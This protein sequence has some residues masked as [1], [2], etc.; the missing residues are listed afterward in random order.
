MPRRRRRKPYAGD[1][2]IPSLAAP[3]G[4]EARDRS[5]EIL[6]QRLVHPD[7]DPLEKRFGLHDKPV[8]FAEFCL[9]LLQIDDLH[10]LIEGDLEYLLEDHIGLWRE[11]DIFDEAAIDAA[12]PIRLASGAVVRDRHFASG[13]EVS[14]VCERLQQIRPTGAE[15]RYRLV[16]SGCTLADSE[17]LPEA[18]TETI[19]AV[20]TDC[21]KTSVM[22]RNVPS[23]W[24]PNQLCRWM[25][26]RGLAG[27]YDVVY[28]PIDLSQMDLSHEANPGYVFVN[29]VEDSYAERAFRI[30]EGFPTRG[31]GRYI[32]VSYA[33]WQGKAA[34]V[35]RC[36]QKLESGQAH[37]EL[38]MRLGVVPFSSSG[39]RI[40][41][42]AWLDVPQLP[43]LHEVASRAASEPCRLFSRYGW[44]SQEWRERVFLRFC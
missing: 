20:V 39:D 31:T 40:S 6:S 15:T 21:T 41:V 10:D 35:A 9:E 19:T 12:V 44:E 43:S 36:L 3:A 38:S 23:D 4:T 1:V 32:H 2:A 37:Q 24:G 30:L 25:N 29:F 42:E 14:D 26:S 5:L 7:V 17:L 16:V 22:V 33:R 11:L 28:V 8:T 13:T 34:Y 27:L 18:N